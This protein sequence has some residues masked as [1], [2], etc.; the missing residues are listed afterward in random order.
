MKDADCLLCD[1][2]DLLEFHDS[3]SSGVHLLS[4]LP[5]AG[6]CAR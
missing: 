4:T 3:H 2:G 1:L 6:H 5:C